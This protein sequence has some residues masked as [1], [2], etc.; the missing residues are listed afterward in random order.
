MSARANKG[1]PENGTAGKAGR[2][3]APWKTLA[4]L[5]CA[6]FFATVSAKPPATRRASA[7]AGQCG[8]GETMQGRAFG[9][10]DAA[11]REGIP[12]FDGGEGAGLLGGVVIA[13]QGSRAREAFAAVHREA[14]GA[15]GPSQMFET[16]SHSLWLMPLFARAVSTPLANSLSSDADW[17]LSNDTDF[18]DFKKH[19][20][21]RFC[22]CLAGKVTRNRTLRGNSEQIGARSGG[23]I[24]A[25]QKE[26]AAQ[27]VT[28]GFDRASRTT[29][30]WP[31]GWTPWIGWMAMALMLACV[32]GL[33]RR[34]KLTT[35]GLWR[36]LA[37][38]AVVLAATL[39]LALL[40]KASLSAVGSMPDGPVGYS[41]VLV[42]AFLLLG[43]SMA[44]GAAAWIGERVGFQGLWS[45]TWLWWA[46]VAVTIALVTP[47]SSPPWVIPALTAGILGLDAMIFNAPGWRQAAAFIPAM[48]AALL[49]LDATP[50][51]YA[52]AGTSGL[53]TV[54][55]LLAA[56]GTTLG[57]MI[58]AAPKG[59]RLA[60]AVTVA[61][62]TVI[63]AVIAALYPPKPMPFRKPAHSEFV[64]D[65]G[66]GRSHLARFTGG[67]RRQRLHE[68]ARYDWHA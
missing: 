13:E 61:A 4:L 27:A 53:P 34:G 67:T 62:G 64:W 29:I 32:W 23:A 12:K 6:L 18:S 14:R 59:T 42:A 65:G 51:F 54:A 50:R 48:V 63:L 2:I 57:P 52:A 28:E 9:S 47:E 36:G 3:A 21:E 26:E 68:A 8:N 35:A 55:V 31:Q 58:V 1:R 46:A 10:N 66:T 45:G 7:P 15:S 38:W 16:R 5:A 20:F 19:G 43:L 30:W 17:R 44:F 33:L 22:F 24:R 49:I 40:L 60:L 37:F 25:S 39:L 56:L 41:T 11:L